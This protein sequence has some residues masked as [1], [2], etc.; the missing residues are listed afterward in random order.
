MLPPK[1]GQGACA[2]RPLRRELNS[3]NHPFRPSFEA[4]NHLER[5]EQ[6]ASILTPASLTSCGLQNFKPT[7]AITRFKGPTNAANAARCLLLPQTLS[8]QVRPGK[9]AGG[10]TPLDWEST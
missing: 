6:V 3:Q 2:E 5:T 4:S 9:V 1:T 7:N 8:T 10:A